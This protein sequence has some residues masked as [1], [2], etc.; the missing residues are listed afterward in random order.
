MF[1]SLAT[2]ITIATFF[3]KRLGGLSGDIYGFIIE[4]S[5]VAI[6]HT[7]LFLLCK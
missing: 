5:E 7:L 6:L 1:V 3:T 4:L 2:L